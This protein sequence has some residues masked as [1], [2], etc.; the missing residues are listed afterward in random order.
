[1]YFSGFIS[2]AMT[3]KIDDKF[4]ESIIEKIPA[5]RLGKPEDIANAVVFLASSIRLYHWRDFT[6]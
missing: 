6:C 5:N 3:D 2:T 1:M 4:K